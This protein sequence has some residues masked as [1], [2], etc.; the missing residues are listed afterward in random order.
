MLS[1]TGLYTNIASKQVDPRNRPWVPQYPLWSDGGDKERWIF[2]PSGTRIDTSDMDRWVFPVGTKIWKE[3]AYQGRRVETRLIQKV[4]APAGLASW[5]FK[6]FRW[7]T[8]GSDAALAPT[9]GVRDAGTTAF[10]TMHDIPSVTDCQ[11][12]HNRGG[13][14]VLGFDALQL[15]ADRDPLAVPAGFLAPGDIT[16]EDLSREGLITNAP[17]SQPRIPGSNSVARW[18]LGY[19]HANCNNC[20]NPQGSAAD[21]GLDFRFTVGARR[22]VDLPAYATTVNRLTTRFTVPGTTLGVDS[23]RIRGGSPELSAVHLRMRTR[24]SNLAMPPLASKVTDADAVN[25]LTE[26]IRGLPTR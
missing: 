14:A 6:S 25:M 7:S 1:S 22:E 8:D 4:A 10:G 21:L 3:F 23:Y 12:C 24:G 16:I 9:E 5:T 19:L 20:H 2:I 13:D 17:G 18:S 11:T 26:W 15:S